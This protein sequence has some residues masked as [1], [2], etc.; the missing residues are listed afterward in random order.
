M[1]LGPLRSL[2]EEAASELLPTWRMRRIIAAAPA[3]APLAANPFCPPDLLALL[4]TESAPEVREAAAS[5]PACP[6]P[7]LA[8]LVL[9]DPV[10]S[11]R[12]AAAAHPAV[13]PRLLVQLAD[14]PCRALRFTVRTRWRIAL[15]N[16]QR[17]DPVGATRLS[18]RAQDARV[19]C[20]AEDCPPGMLTSCARDPEWWVRAAVARN[21]QCP[22]PVLRLLGRDSSEWVRA[23][24]AFNPQCPVGLL[25]DLAADP[26]PMVL[27]AI[28]AN[29]QCPD[30]L[31]RQLL[32]AAIWP[33][34]QTT[35]VSSAWRKEWALHISSA[36]SAVETTA[37]GLVTDGFKGSIAD[38]GSVVA[39]VLF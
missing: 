17:C 28:E 14:D 3:H 15:G 36:G 21:P 4:A 11:V 32:G 12:C 18:A 8:R 20:M 27:C 9:R 31:R 22:T 38:L 26:S 23:G 19:S 7:V 13:D 33:P 2:A 25:E 37:W 24:V 35:A 5:N 34:P 6:P 10:T 1:Q 29:D 39:G 16:V 30:S